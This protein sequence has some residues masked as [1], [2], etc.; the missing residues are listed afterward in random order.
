MGEDEP[1]R[2]QRPGGFR[3]KAKAG[4]VSTG[5]ASG[6]GARRAWLGVNIAPAELERTLWLFALLFLAAL[7]LVVGRTARDALF[8]TRF[9]VTWIAPMWIAYAGVSSLTA[10][11]FAPLFART[12]RVRLVLGFALAAS[13]SLAALR[14]AIAYDLGPAYL[15]FYVWSEV[16]ANLTSVLVWTIAQDLH[17]AQSAKRLFGIIGSGRAIGTLVCGFVTGSIVRTIGT[18]NLIFVL[19][20]AFGAIAAIT[21]RIDG[22]S[23]LPVP[24]A[25]GERAI[26][27]RTTSLSILRSRYLVALGVMTLLLFT[28]LTVGDYQ[29]KAIARATYPDTDELAHFMANFYGLMGLAG[30]FVQLVITPRLLDRFGVAAGMLA[31]PLCFTAATLLL[32]VAPGVPLAAVLKGSDNALQFTIHDATLQLLFFPIPPAQRERVRT[33]MG[34][35]LKPLGYAVGAMLLIAIAPSA[36]E[37]TPGPELVERAAWL[38]LYTVPLGLAVLALVPFVRRGYVRAMRRTLVRREIEPDDAATNPSAL[39]LLRGALA[40]QDSPQVLFA[41]DRLREVAPEV[42]L[43]AIPRLA[44]HAAPEVRAVALRQARELGHEDGAALGRAAFHDVARQVRVEAVETVAAQ[45][46]DDAHDDML[47]LAASTDD[48]ATR[49]AAIAA[50]VRYCG[51]DGMLDGAP[52]LRGLLD[53]DDPKERTAAA[54]VLGMVGEASLFR[55]LARLLRDADPDVR[56]AAV[57]AAQSVR[58]RRL[59]PALVGCLSEARLVQPAVN[60]LA[61]LGNPAVVELST[62]LGDPTTELHAR[63]LLPRALARVATREALDALLTHLDEPDATVRQKVLASASRLRLLLQAPAVPPVAVR[64]RIDREIADHERERDA[65]LAVR[66]ALVRPL[67]DAYMLASLRKGLVRILRLCEL[68]YPRE[69]VASVRAHLFGSDATLRANAFEVLESLLDRALRKHLV[70]LVERFHALRARGTLASPS[71]GEGPTNEALLAWLRAELGR[72]DDYLAALVLDAIAYRQLDVAGPLALGALGHAS[73]FVRENAAIAVAVTRP[74]GAHAALA[75]LVSDR[76]PV[77]ADY[78]R[79]WIRTGST[80]LD[81]TD[82]MYTTVEKVLFLQ[83]IPVFSRVSGDALVGLARSSVVVSMVPGEVLFRQGEPGGALYFIIS[84]EVTL[85]VSEHEVA[86][87]GTDDV[88]GEMSIFDSEPR[89]ATARVTEEAELLRVSAE[90]FRD[91]VRDS[92]EVAVAV[93]QV[94]NRRLRE[95]DRRLATYQRGGET[96]SAESAEP[97]PRRSESPPPKALDEADLE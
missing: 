55:A 2:P 68:A 32:F 65:Y 70:D 34:A 86:R 25:A 7:V 44:S 52:L 1:A 3:L 39:R 89:A 4:E 96:K 78:A 49:T 18:E 64:P 56:R 83:R 11:A 16:V 6:G 76:D 43:E 30:I 28:A 5:A 62:R 79:Y 13:L 12:P 94:L 74:A 93:I 24:T 73:P 26:V 63:L 54:R 38:G 82:E 77:V 17:D 57:A 9:P 42:V 51:L 20:G 22:L 36:A 31:M 8:L 95:A 59:L 90:E 71:S 84:G 67:L 72:P 69:V 35:V 33:H 40:S 27:D 81:P 61:A 66:S 97:A 85:T 14:V 46:C 10:I 87:L 21:L 41:L 60:A 23:P 50:L 88:F 75:A 48:P 47:R 15:V 53:S 29:F 19:I 37:S 58:D 45:L 80:G 92:G 91:A